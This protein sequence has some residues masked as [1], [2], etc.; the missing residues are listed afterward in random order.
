[1]DEKV[2]NIGR[3]ISTNFSLLGDFSHHIHQEGLQLFCF[4]FVVL[5][6]GTHN[7]LV[8]FGSTTKLPTMQHAAVL[9]TSGLE[10]IN[11]VPDDILKG[12]EFET[13]LIIFIIIFEEK[14]K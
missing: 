7:L 3:P 13:P 14:P 12:F 9:P 4:C 10:V 1:M 8:K 2:A 6:D 5:R 11:N